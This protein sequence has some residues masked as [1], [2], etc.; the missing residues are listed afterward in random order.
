MGK[1]SLLKGCG[2]LAEHAGMT[3]RRATGSAIE[4]DLTFGLIG[5][6]LDRDVAGLD[7][8]GRP[9]SRAPPPS[10][11]GCSTRPV[12]GR[13]PSRARGPAPLDLLARL[14]PRASGPMAL[15]VDDAHQGDRESLAALAYAARRIADLPVLLVVAFRPPA[16]PSPELAAISE[17]AGAEAGELVAPGPLSAEGVAA[18][19]GSILGEALARGRR[20]LPGGERGEPATPA[21]ARRADALRGGFLGGRREAA[22]GLGTLRGGGRPARRLSADAQTAAR[23]AAVLGREATVARVGELTGLPDP[24]AAVDEL[25]TAGILLPAL[26]ITFA[27]PTLQEAVSSSSSPRSARGC[28]PRRRRCLRRAASG[29][30]GCGPPARVGARGRHRVGADPARRGSDRAPAGLPDG[31]PAA[32]PRAH[33]PRPRSRWG[34]CSRSWGARNR[35]AATRPRWTT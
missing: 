5:Q 20:R 28:T 17:A 3:V 25:V 24:E 8:A 4:R 10:P 19:A 2:G 32:D 18:V 13:G 29:R 11:A 15:L 22:R 30:A 12:R 27:H 14:E 21:N 34:W 7:E 16:E 31:G 35:A 23:A 1:T 6:L 26:P 33:R 9:S